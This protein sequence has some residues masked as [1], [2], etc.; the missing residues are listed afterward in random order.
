MN[1]RYLI[2]ADWSARPVK[3]S[4]YVADCDK[5]RIDR[6]F[7]D[8][9]DLHALLDLA[10]E[11]SVDGPV[12]IGID[13]VFGLPE[14]YWQLVLSKQ[15][16]DQPKTFVDWL[17]QQN[18]S[19]SFFDTVVNPQDWQ[20]DRPWFTVPPGQGGLTAFTSKVAGGM[21]RRVDLATRG[22]PLFAVAGIPGTVGGGTRELWRELIDHLSGERDF[23]IWPF[24]GGLASLL[25]NHG[26]VI[27][28]TY[29]R[30]AYAVALADELPT[31]KMAGPKTSRQWRDDVCD[32]IMQAKWV[33]THAV[34]LGDLGPPRGSEDD[35]DAHLT[36]AA[37][38]RCVLEGRRLAHARWIDP[39]AEGSMLLAGVVDLDRKSS[40]A[41]PTVRASPP[42]IAGR[43]RAFLCPILGCNKVFNGSKAGWDTH[44]GSIKMHRLWQPTVKDPAKRKRLFRGEFCNWFQ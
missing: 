43:D 35:F 12:L 13:V 18:P 7:H 32:R 31:E 44:V 28:E 5:R 29:P 39:K 17:R 40:A 30:L 6:K 9:W 20:V 26:T 21:R 11:L 25:A 10:R 36:A 38:L 34:S 16:G 15:N 27:C 42:S 4:V 22:N 3:R 24:E 1:C 37:G 33:G 41:T 19:G 14:G 23:A 2:S 8:R